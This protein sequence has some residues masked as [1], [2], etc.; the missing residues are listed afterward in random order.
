MSC[1][2]ELSRMAVVF[3]NEIRTYMTLEIEEKNIKVWQNDFDYDP[4]I[5]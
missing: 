3:E 2:R 5:I 4:I 1:P